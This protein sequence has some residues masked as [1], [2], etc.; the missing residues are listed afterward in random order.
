MH[1][2]PHHYSASAAGTTT[3]AVTVSSP[4]LPDLATETPT[5]FGGP[6]GLWSPETMLTAA[7][8]DCFALTWRSVASASGFEWNDLS[9]AAAGVLDRIDH[10][11]RF[12]AMHLTVRLGVPAGTDPARADRLVRK[13]ESACLITN[14]LT[15]E[16][17]FDLQ[18]SEG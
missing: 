10:V 13:T 15:C 7:V 16:T 6:G 12:T 2:F 4:D 11:T 8:A 9:V 1:S 17:T 3:G 5:E 18:L 14:S